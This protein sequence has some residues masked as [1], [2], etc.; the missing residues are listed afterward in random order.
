MLAFTMGV[1]VASAQTSF[2]AKVKANVE[3]VKFSTDLDCEN[4]AKKI[5]NVIPFKK[6]VK[7]CVVDVATKTVEV[8]F[9]TR[10]TNSETLVAELNKIDVHVVEPA[11]CNKEQ[12]A[13]PAVSEHI[14]TD[15]CCGGHDHNHAH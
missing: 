12:C 10:K 11:A 2:K 1:G 5:L 6:G 8:T 14:K 3:T 7:D 4:C 15:A 9:D 13:G